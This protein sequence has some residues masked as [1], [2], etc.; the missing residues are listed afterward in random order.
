MCAATAFAISELER[1][2]HRKKSKEGNFRIVLMGKVSQWL[3]REFN[4]PA[5]SLTADLI[6]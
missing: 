5:D 1:T 3:Q 6:G 2:F 4:T